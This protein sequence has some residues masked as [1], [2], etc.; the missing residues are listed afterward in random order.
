MFHLHVTSTLDL[1]INSFFVLLFHF[2][3]RLESVSTFAVRTSWSESHLQSSRH[4][5][6]KTR[7]QRSRILSA[8]WRHDSSEMLSAR[9]HQGFN[10][11]GRTLFLNNISDLCFA[12]VLR[13][14]AVLIRRSVRLSPLC[15]YGDSQRCP[16]QSRRQRVGLISPR[17]RLH[18]GS[19]GSLQTDRKASSSLN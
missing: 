9:T 17:L 10:G 13:P 7:S 4:T 1:S 8:P 16:L 15:H 6:N 12:T 3:V 18:S 19:N 14:Y 2:P 5:G 11:R